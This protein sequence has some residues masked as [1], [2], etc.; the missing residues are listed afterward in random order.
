MA[1]PEV[2]AIIPVFNDWGSLEAAIPRSI[3]ILSRITGD[4][5]ILI[6]EDGS[7]D[8]STECARQWEEKDHHV[9]LLL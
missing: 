5:E 8:G 7:N 1:V 4:F 3:E 9:R 6:A 2:T